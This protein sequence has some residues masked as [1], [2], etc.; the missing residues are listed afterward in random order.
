MERRRCSDRQDGA[1][2]FDDGLGGGFA[3]I[4]HGQQQFLGTVH[5]GRALGRS[6]VADLHDF[7][8]GIA[9]ANAVNGFERTGNDGGLNVVHAAGD[10]DDPVHFPVLRFHF[11]VNVADSG[12][13]LQ[14]AKFKFVAEQ[15]FRLP[16]DGPDDIL[17]LDRAVHFDISP[18]F[19]FHGLA[20]V[21][22]SAVGLVVVSS[23][24]ILSPLIHINQAA[25]GHLQRRSPSVATT[26]RGE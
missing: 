7:D 18:N 4:D 15:T 23:H 25:S 3:G 5:H 22:A 11:N 1:N 8:D 6:D 2:L 12:R 19:V 21:S 16:H 14:F 9:R 20:F 24:W 17:S 13:S 26:R 10:D